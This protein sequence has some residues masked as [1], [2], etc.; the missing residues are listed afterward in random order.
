MWVVHRGP[1][2]K[3]VHVFNMR[4]LY[5][6]TSD[7]NVRNVSEEASRS[8]LRTAS[9]KRN[10]SKLGL[11]RPTGNASTGDEVE[12]GGSRRKQ[13]L[14]MALTGLHVQSKPSGFSGKSGS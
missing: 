4:S 7:V 6:I 3:T 1:Q 11:R 12:V 9:A 13:E 10:W 5:L 14:E 2:G 8:P